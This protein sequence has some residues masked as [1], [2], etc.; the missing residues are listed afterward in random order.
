MK[1]DSS[2]YRH[3][4]ALPGDRWLLTGPPGMESRHRIN[5]RIPRDSVRLRHFRLL[6]FPVIQSKNLLR[7]VQIPSWA[8]Y[9]PAIEMYSYF[10]YDLPTV[11]CIYT[12][13]VV[14]LE[15]E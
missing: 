12:Y 15:F 1:T 5:P 8:P 3:N 13:S 4:T 14:V 6:I 2:N 7:I 11:I 10:F 9:D